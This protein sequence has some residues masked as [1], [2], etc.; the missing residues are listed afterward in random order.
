MKSTKT[1]MGNGSGILST[2]FTSFFSLLFFNIHIQKQ[3][4]KK[5][6]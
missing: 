1:L 6:H 3:Y 5:E 2:D 4:M